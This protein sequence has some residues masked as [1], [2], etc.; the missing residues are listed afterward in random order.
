MIYIAGKPLVSYVISHGNMVIAKGAPI[1]SKG[2]TSGLSKLVMNKEAT[3][4]R[5]EIKVPELETT[6]GGISCERIALTAPI[7]YGDSDITFQN[8]VGQSPFGAMPGE[9]KPILIGGHDGTFFAPLEQIVIGDVISI[10]TDYGKLEYEVITTRIA[11]AKDTTAYDL[12]QEK[13]QLILYT[14]YPFGQLIGNRS[15]RYYVYCNRILDTQT[16]TE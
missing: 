14:C 7:F 6:Y 10:V 1:A 15:E 2:D 11:D 13:E 3:I 9:G 16:A 5:S 8:G 4:D 12:S